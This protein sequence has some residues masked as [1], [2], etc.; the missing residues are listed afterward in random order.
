MLVL[1]LVMV[2]VDRQPVVIQ[3][4]RDA[5]HAAQQCPQRLALRLV[6]LQLPAEASQ[7]NI[8][9]SGARDACGVHAG[10]QLDEVA[11]VSLAVFDRSLSLSLSRR[12][13]G[14]QTRGGRDLVA[15]IVFILGDEHARQRLQHFQQ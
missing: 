5:G 13:D 6:D 11:N 2:R 9:H 14:G 1:M 12:R 7:E 3:R 4:H 10:Y 8:L 15:D